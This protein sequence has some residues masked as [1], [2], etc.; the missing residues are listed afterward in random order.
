MESSLAGKVV[1]GLQIHL[2][3]TELPINDTVVL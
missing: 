2:I 1:P 3:I